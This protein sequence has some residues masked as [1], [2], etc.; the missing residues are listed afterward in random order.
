MFDTDWSTLVVPSLVQV[1]QTSIQ[2]LEFLAKNKRNV[3]A[4]HCVDGRSN[5]AMLFA[6]LMLVGKV[7]KR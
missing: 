7:Y 6:A 2:C 1:L 4:I 3:I 5:S